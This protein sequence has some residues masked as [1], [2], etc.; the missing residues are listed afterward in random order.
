MGNLRIYATC[1]LS[2]T[3]Q[4]FV[5]THP[6]IVSACTSLLE[7]ICKP[8]TQNLNIKTHIWS[9]YLVLNMMHHM[10]ICFTSPTLSKH[11][12]VWFYTQVYFEV[13]YWGGNT[14]G[15]PTSYN[16][17][18]HL[19]RASGVPNYLHCCIPVQSG[20]NIKAGRRYLSN[21]WDQQLCDLLEFGFPFSRI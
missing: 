16:A 19:I 2:L 14:V 4:L 9:L 3:S 13:L 17:G 7:N 21:Y 18:H 6:K 1:Y 10:T 11:K 12:Q 5:K 15:L 20:L 8:E